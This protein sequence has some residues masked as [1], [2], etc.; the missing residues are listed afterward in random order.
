MGQDNVQVNAVLPG[1][2]DSALTHRARQDIQGLEERVVARAPAGRWG[3]PEDFAGIAVSLASPAC[4]FLTGTAIP[5]DGGYSS[6]AD[7]RKIPSDRGAHA[8]AQMDRGA[9]EEARPRGHQEGD[10]IAYSSASP[11]RPSGTRLPSSA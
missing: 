7:G 1:W 11:M 10:P 4:D 8:A 5:V 3:V 9:G 6:R 2:I